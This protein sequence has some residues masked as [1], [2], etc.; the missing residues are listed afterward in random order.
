MR[1]YLKIGSK[2]ELPNGSTATVKSNYTL[3]LKGT[4]SQPMTVTTKGHY[5]REVL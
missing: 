3:N 1:K 2:V 4:S 5:P